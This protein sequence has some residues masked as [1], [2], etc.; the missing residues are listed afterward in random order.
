MHPLLGQLA[1][2][3][4]LIGVEGPREVLQV[5]FW[6]YKTAAAGRAWDSTAGTTTLD[7]AT[8]ESCARLGALLWQA[9]ESDFEHGIQPGPV[10]RFDGGTIGFDLRFGDPDDDGRAVEAIVEGFAELGCTLGG[11]GGEPIVSGGS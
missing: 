5:V 4:S 11:A 7:G 1:D 10:F 2:T 3:Q 6:A 8:V 9:G